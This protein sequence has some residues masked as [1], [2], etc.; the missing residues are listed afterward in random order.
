MNRYEVLFSYLKEQI[1]DVLFKFLGISNLMEAVYLGV[2]F[3]ER[4]ITKMQNFFFSKL[5]C[6][7][8]GHTDL[9]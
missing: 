3:A 4:G 5:I 2:I 1:L 7:F 8:L 9:A 6:E